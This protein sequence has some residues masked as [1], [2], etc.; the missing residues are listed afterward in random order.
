[1]AKYK[2]DFVYLVYRGEKPYNNKKILAGLYGEKAPPYDR[3]LLFGYIKKVLENKVEHDA[4]TIAATKALRDAL[5]GVDLMQQVGIKWKKIQED[6]LPETIHHPATS[7]VRAALNNKF[8]EDDK[9]Q[10]QHAIAELSKMFG[11]SSRSAEKFYKKVKL[12]QERTLQAFKA[13]FRKDGLE[14]KEMTAQEH[15]IE[16]KIR[17][18]PTGS[19]NTRK[20]IERI[21]ELTGQEYREAQALYYKVRKNKQ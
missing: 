6:P 18:M 20:N 2:K 10:K 8:P 5:L 7:I 1:M 13:M 21:M 4:D 17:D 15:S 11:Y 16:D 14:Y 9:T 3:E 19:I 12:S